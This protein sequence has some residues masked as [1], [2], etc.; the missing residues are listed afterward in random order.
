LFDAAYCAFVRD[1]KIPLSIFEIPGARECA[2]EFRSF[3]KTA[4]FTG[5]RCAFTVIPDSV[6]VWDSTGKAHKLLDLWNRRHS[7]KFN[8]VSY[9]VQVAAAAV[10]S[11][12]GQKEV[13]ELTDYYMS[14]ARM[15][16]DRLL[17]WNLE[18]TGGENGPYVWVKT[19]NDSWESFDTLL[20]EAQVVVTPGSG[21]GT[22]GQG[23][24]RISA[25]NHREK[26]EE[27]LGRLE[28]VLG[29]TL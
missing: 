4:G 12:E 3:S 19:G 1:P 15:I 6:L 10:Y 26:V 2:V 22:C 9:P 17:S 7:T 18:V 8:G 5:A 13:R 11:P 25:F 16:R 14:N 27:A 29:K 28:Q 20:N 23:Y 24:I 21:F